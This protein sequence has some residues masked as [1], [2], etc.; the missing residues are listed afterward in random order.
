[1]GLF[2]LR[3]E[4]S[5]QLFHHHHSSRPNGWALT[6]LAVA[7]STHL[8]A[9]MERYC[10]SRSPSQALLMCSSARGA[11]ICSSLLVLLRLFKRVLVLASV[12]TG[13]ITA[14]LGLL[15]A[16]RQYCSNISCENNSK[17]HNSNKMHEQEKCFTL[18]PVNYQKKVNGPSTFFA[19]T[20]GISRL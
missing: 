12:Q 8:R 15:C 9:E 5:G 10:T 20:L 6:G 2:F 14:R 17:V 16:A 1:M 11:H 7:G 3:A 19:S 18:S 13:C 4:S